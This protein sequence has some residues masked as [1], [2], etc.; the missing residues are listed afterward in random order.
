MKSKTKINQRMKKKTKSNLAE[1]I[2][3]AKKNNLLEL[4]SAISIS[5]RLQAKVNLEDIEKAGKTSVII[6]GKVLSKGEVSKKVKVYA[7]GFSESAR[8]KLEKAGAEVKD[9]FES[10]KKGEKIEGEILK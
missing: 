10:L 5:T 3:L 7:L 9:I 6:P 1:A 8:T 2:Y 4:A